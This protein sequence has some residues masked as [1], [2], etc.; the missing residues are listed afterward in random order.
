[1]T[2]YRNYNPRQSSLEAARS[3]LTAAANAAMASGALPQTELPAFNVEIPADSKNGDVASNLAMVGARAFHKAPRQIAEAVVG[4]LDLTGS[5][6]AR[7][8]IAGPGFINLY[9]GSAWFT[10]V[11]CAACAGQEYGR[12]NAGQ[13]KR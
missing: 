3:L 7:V 6:F 11:L 5:P 13:G 1:M 4:A 9:L 8:E 2:D 12:T 10:S